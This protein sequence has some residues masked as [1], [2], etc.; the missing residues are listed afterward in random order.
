[1]GRAVLSETRAVLS[2][3]SPPARAQ[4]GILHS[5][6]RCDRKKPSMQTIAGLEN[7]LQ[8]DR[9]TISAEQKGMICSQCPQ[10]NGEEAKSLG[11]CMW[12]FYSAGQLSS[13]LQLLSVPLLREKGG[14]NMM[15]RAQGLR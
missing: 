15:K 3:Q 10:Q 5:K 9:N 14:E 2:D 11:Y 12:G 4:F 8:G 7:N 1:M 6:N 13:P